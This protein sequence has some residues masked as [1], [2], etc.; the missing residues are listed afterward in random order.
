MSTSNPL[1]GRTSVVL[2]VKYTMRAAFK[3]LDKL[4][5]VF[6]IVRTIKDQFKLSKNFLY[7]LPVGFDKFTI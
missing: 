6:L 4:L 5:L 3:K 2:T 1:A 7:Q